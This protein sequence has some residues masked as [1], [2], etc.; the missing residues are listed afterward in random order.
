MV[1]HHIYSPTKETVHG[2]NCYIFRPCQITY[3]NKLLIN[4]CVLLQRFDQTWNLQKAF[5]VFLEVAENALVS[6]EVAKSVANVAFL[7]INHCWPYSPHGSK[8]TCVKVVQDDN[9]HL[10]IS[11]KLL[12]IYWLR[13]AADTIDE[14][15]TPSH[16]TRVQHFRPGENSF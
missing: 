12:Q 1:F 4:I 3:W 6:S 7:R 10:T 13:K 14:V 16:P 9:P 11:T 15:S 5:F 8:G 2:K